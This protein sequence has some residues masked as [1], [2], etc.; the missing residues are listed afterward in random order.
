[1]TQKRRRLAQDRA[2]TRDIALLVNRLLIGQV[3]SYGSVT[4]TQS[5]TTTTITEPYIMENSVVLLTPTT[6]NAAA[7][8]AT[9]YITCATGSATVTHANNAQ[10]DRTFMFVVLGG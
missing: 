5:A 9:T 7:A 4:L 6:A 8:L 1:M 3:N 2:T 10:T